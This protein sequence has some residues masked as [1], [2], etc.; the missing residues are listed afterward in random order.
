MYIRWMMRE[1][2]VNRKIQL[3]GI[4][5]SLLFSSILLTSC[6]PINLSRHADK[7]VPLSAENRNRLEGRY[8]NI[9]IDSTR[10]DRS[11]FSRMSDKEVTELDS[12]TI[13]IEVFSARSINV[14]LINDGIP[15]HSQ[16]LKGKFRSGLFMTRKWNANMVVGPLIWVLGSERFYLG[17]T[18]NQ[19]LLILRNGGVSFAL[20]VAFPIMAGGGG[21]TSREYER[22]K[23]GE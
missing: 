3:I 16:I 5:L 15:I 4:S 7:Y 6:A 1:A 10:F 13:S 19:D 2:L 23:N 9:A 20:L 11:I 12:L 14:V 17:S 22:I 8:A 18:D 21:S